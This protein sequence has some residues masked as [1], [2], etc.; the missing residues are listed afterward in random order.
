MRDEVRPEAPTMR[1][2]VETIVR[3]LSDRPEEARV[4]ETHEGRTVVYEIAVPEGDRGRLIGREGRTV[5]A[6]RAF[7]G[8]AA[9]ARGKKVI[10]RV[11]D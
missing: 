7:V 6:L 8:A 9:S 2:L 5:R 11:R 1:R 3:R 4:A 10:V